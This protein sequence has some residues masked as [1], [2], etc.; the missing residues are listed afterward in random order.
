MQFAE[1]VSGRP[2]CRFLHT[3]Y[4]VAFPMAIPSYQT[5]GGQQDGL[6]QGKLGLLARDQR[7]LPRRNELNGPHRILLPCLTTLKVRT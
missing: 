6:K 3:G 2:Q 1:D 4:L 7:Y 5:M